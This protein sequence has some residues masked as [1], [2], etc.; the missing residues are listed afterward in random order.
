MTL[1]N[2]REINKAK[3]KNNKWAKSV[4]LCVMCAKYCI[5]SVAPGTLGKPINLED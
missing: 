1:R 4:I 2:G 3:N 5:V